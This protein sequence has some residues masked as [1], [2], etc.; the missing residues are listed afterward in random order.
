[1]WE[2]NKLYPIHLYGILLYS[3]IFLRVKIFTDLVDVKILFSILIQYCMHG[4][5]QKKL[6][7]NLQI[8]KSQKINL[9][10]YKAIQYLI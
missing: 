4:Y 8:H 1:M 10:K 3:P 5:P 9:Q 6:F 7:R 2:I